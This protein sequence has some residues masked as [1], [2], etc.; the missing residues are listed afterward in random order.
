MVL[1]KT[2]KIAFLV[3]FE[4]LSLGIIFLLSIFYLFGGFNLIK[5]ECGLIFLLVN[6]LF[7][8]FLMFIPVLMIKF[9][10]LYIS[11]LYIFV[12]IV[13]ML[14]FKNA[15]IHIREKY[16]EFSYMDWANK[17]IVRQIM[18][19]DLKSDKNF[20]SYNKDQVSE[21]LGLPDEKENNKFYYKTYPGYIVVEFQN[22]NRINQIYWEHPLD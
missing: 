16:S 11:L 20:L 13:F 1:S 10:V 18:Y 7:L 12:C 14:A 21:K 6:L 19:K 15:N 2:N 17:P 22:D 4:I 5:Y 3:F 8:F 9:K